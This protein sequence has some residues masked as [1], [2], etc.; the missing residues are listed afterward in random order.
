MDGHIIQPLFEIPSDERR[1]LGSVNVLSAEYPASIITDGVSP[2]A[3]A[4]DV[5]SKINKAL[6]GKDYDSIANLFT[7]S[8]VWRDHL[9]LTWDLRTFQ[10]SSK[11]LDILK[12]EC[13]LAKLSLDKNAAHR[14]PQVSTLDAAGKVKVIQFFVLLSTTLG[15]G[16][17]V[18]RLTQSNGDWKILTLFTSLKE[19]NGFGEPRATRRPYG[20]PKEAQAAGYKNW[21]EVR[22]AERNFEENDPAVLIIGAGQ[23]GLSSAARL[24]M[25]NVPTLV[26]DRAERV[27]DSWRKRYHSLVLHDPVWFDHLPYIN[28]PDSWPIFTPKDKIAGFFEAYVEMLE[29]NVWMRTKL[30]HSSW[31]DSSKQ[32]TVTVERQIGDRKETRTFHPRHVVQATGHSG[33]MNFP[34]VKGMSTFKGRLCHASEFPGAD[35]GSRGKHAVIVGCCNSAHD[36]AQDFYTNGYDV[37]MVQRSSTCVISSD[38][39]VQ[40]GLYPLYSEVGPPVEDADII[41]FSRPSSYLKTVQKEVAVLQAQN[42]KDTLEGLRRA[43][44]AVD[45]GPDHAGLLFKYYQRGGGYYIDVGASQLII[46]GK[47]KIKQ[48][49]EVEEILE[50]GIKFADGTVLPADEIIFATGYQNMRT[51]SRL[52]FGDQV[53]DRLQDVWGFDEEG[54]FRAMWRPS[55]HPGFWYMGGN[56]QLCRYFSQ[57]LAL[58]IKAYE[59]GLVKY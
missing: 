36:I 41:M 56:L 46:D 26:I 32:W 28:F 49:Q 15:Q 59:A 54:E 20:K 12:N 25:L 8:S 18:V 57:C 2:D 39:I 5:V 3:V 21:A 34:R 24:K 51:Q 33:M 31:D 17:G 7:E 10:G 44:F 19:I 22:T 6:E 55:G 35:S 58:Q 14:A 4:E 48:G 30:V 23:A 16:L 13:R 47:I 42:D 50:D 43:G 37:T 53:A 38:S 27:G 40:I 52:I 45:M 11:V 1:E 9:C 29:L